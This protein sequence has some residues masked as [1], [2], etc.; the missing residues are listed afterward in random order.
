MKEHPEIAPCP[1][2]GRSV[3]TLSEETDRSGNYIGHYVECGNPC[4]ARGPRH[5]GSM[6]VTLWNR[7]LPKS[8]GTH[9]PDGTARQ[10]EGCGAKLAPGQHWAFCGETDMGS[11]PALC[12]RC[13]GEFIP[14]A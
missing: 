10:G 8:G 14:E 9:Y 1:F 2:C 11:A 6:A 5:E 3:A 7:G 12:T 13:G 4:Y